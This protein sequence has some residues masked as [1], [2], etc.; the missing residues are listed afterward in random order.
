[1][2]VLSIYSLDEEIITAIF[3]FTKPPNPK[4]AI[5]VSK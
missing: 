2:F 3:E 4:K 5:F 1:M